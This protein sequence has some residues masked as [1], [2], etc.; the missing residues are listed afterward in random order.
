MRFIVVSFRQSNLRLW[1]AQSGEHDVIILD[2][3][4]PKLDGLS[5]LKALR[6]RQCP[7]F[8]LI[9]TARDAPTDKVQG[10]NLGADDYLVKPFMFAE[11]LARIKAL[12][13]RKYE[14]RTTVVTVGDLEIDTARRT[15]R[16]GSEVIELSG[17]EYALLEYFALNAD[18]TVSRTDIWQHV[19]D[20]NAS[21]ESN[22]VDVFVGLLRRKIERPGCARLIHT[23]RGQGYM[24][25]HKGADE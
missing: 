23:R 1:H 19:Y 14:I 9:L 16:R 3:M 8:V 10:L 22:V 21:P 20:F 18:R 2:L 11:L 13:R 24:L 15:V 17:R 12:V 4:L 25:S 7:A 5:V 6:R